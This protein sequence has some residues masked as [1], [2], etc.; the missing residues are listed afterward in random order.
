MPDPLFPF[1]EHPSF[2]FS[3]VGTIRSDSR[4]G[5]SPSWWRHGKIP[6]FALIAS[7]FA[8]D[9]I[10]GT[11]E[12]LGIGTALGLL[13]YTAA[14]LALRTDL[15]RKEQAFLISIALLNVT[16]TAANL[17]PDTM[18]NLLIGLFLPVVITF[19]PRKEGNSF[20]PAKRYVSWWGYKFFQLNQV[21][22]TVG[23]V[24]G[25]IPLAG[26]LIIGAVL[27]LIFLS[28]FADGNPVVASI[29]SAM[30]EW[31]RIYCSWLIPDL[32]T[33]TDILLWCVGAVAF[34]IAARP[35]PCFSFTENHPVH[36]GRPW[37]P[38]LPLISLLFIN[39]AFLVNNGTDIA[40]LWRG[41]VPEGISQTA[42]LHNGADSILLAAFLSALVLLVLFRPEGSVRASKAGTIMGFILAVQTG[43]LAASVGLRLYYQIGDFG[44]SPNRVTAAIYLLMGV[45]FLY[46]LFRYMAGSGNW[47]RYGKL[48]GAITLVFLV[49]AGIRSPSQLSGDLNLMTMNGHPDWYFSDGDLPRFELPENLPFAMAVYRRVGSDTEAGANVY[50]MIQEALNSGRRIHN[51]RS[52]SLRKW[53]RDRQRELFRQL[54]TPAAQATYGTEAWHPS[55]RPTGMKPR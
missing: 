51:W 7:G 19:F 21:K 1:P 30:N 53:N 54:P 42:Y 8:A 40:F 47:L 55:S 32:G 25:K 45:C 14:F 6:L 28:I 41:S 31:F 9:F 27:F 38:S 50:A 17:S 39:L 52:F 44:F 29:R 16:A 18:Y 5:L 10:F 11:M 46:L 24:L 3:N 20:N 49:L 43:L 37:L 26:S 34:G 2:P 33:I 36:P 12:G 15:S 48:S 23:K 4:G 22:E 35:R 13:L